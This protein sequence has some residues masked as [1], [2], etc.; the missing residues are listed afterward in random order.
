M[1]KLRKI[2]FIGLTF[3]CLAVIVWFSWFRQPLPDD[4]GQAVSRA[5]AAK[6]TAL[7]KGSLDD[8]EAALSESRFPEEERDLWYIKYADYLYQQGLWTEVET[9]PEAAGME[10][11]YTYSELWGLLDRL[12]IDSQWTNRD[13]Q[14]DDWEKSVP[15]SLWDQVWEEIRGQADAEGEVAEKTVI[16]YGTPA[17]LPELPAWTAATDQGEFGFEGLNLN[18]CLDRKINVWVRGSE[19]LKVIDISG[20]AVCYENVLVTRLENESRRTE[21]GEE[22]GTFLSFFLDGVT[23]TYY[24]SGQTLAES[25]GQV[26]ADVTVEDGRVTRLDVKQESIE[27]KVLAVKEDAIEIQGYGDV[28]RQD[29]MKVYKT[30]GD[31]EMQTAEDIRLGSDAQRF[32]VADGKICGVLTERAFEATSIR[33][34]LKTNGFSGTVHDRVELTCD[35]E[36]T[37]SYGDRTD[38]CQAGQVLSWQPGDACFEEG[39]VVV[40][41]AEGGKVQILSLERACGTPAYSGEVEL[42]ADNGG[43]VLINEVLLEEYLVSVLPSEMPESYGLEALKAQA[44]CARSYACRQMEGN[45]YREYGA[46]VDDS[47]SFQVYNNSAA[48]ELARQAVEETYG[49]VLTYDGR[50]ITTYYFSTSCGHTTDGGAWGGDASAFPYLAGAWMEESAPELDLKEEETFRNFIRESD[51]TAFEAGFPWYRWHVSVPAAQLGDRI[52]AYL[53]AQSSAP[54]GSVLVRQSDG[55]F[56]EGNLSSIGTLQ[57]AEIV[58]RGEGGIARVLEATGTAGTVRILYQNAIRT[59]LCS[60][61]YCYTRTGDTIVREGT[62]LPS[63]YIYLE[64]EYSGETVSGY[65]IYGGGSGHGVGMS[66]NAACYLGRIGK[67]YDEILNSFFRDC[68]LARLY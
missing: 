36:F 23:K 50:I 60:P 8:C 58:E 34:L 53:A 46:H 10:G 25:Y 22:N 13:S 3:L 56:T 29:A 14:R 6:E 61:D 49:Q 65:T 43:I 4:S 11:E 24:L 47:T 20:E 41:P 21:E 5:E 30:Y 18:D 64:P 12:G 28:P 66:Q 1:K 42:L 7:L 40:R 17:N 33:V 39:R 35:T 9:P 26:L 44:V 37:V 15:R 57:K 45:A 54:S 27:G 67:T 62:L 19:I 51:E 59:A 68:V 52:N 48:S 32:V 63:A 55:S 16:L 31:L 38:V 2:V